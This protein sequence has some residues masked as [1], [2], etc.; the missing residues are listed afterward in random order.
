[1]FSNLI[2]AFVATTLLGNTPAGSVVA[3]T[4]KDLTKSFLSPKQKGSTGTQAMNMQ[5]AI[6]PSVFSFKDDVMSDDITVIDAVNLDTKFDSTQNSFP[7]GTKFDLAGLIRD[8]A[9]R[10][11]MENAHTNNA[12]QTV[13]SFR[14]LTKIT[15]YEEESPISINNPTL[16]T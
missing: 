11:M 13:S 2:K 16:I 12:M 7:L 5:G 8:P 9:Y 14:D 4:F 3:G 6:E 15:P 1:M 10:R